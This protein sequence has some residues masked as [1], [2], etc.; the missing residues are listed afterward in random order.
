MVGLSTSPFRSSSK[1]ALPE[2][3]VGHMQHSCGPKAVQPGECNGVQH[4][5]L[6]VSTFC[7]SN[8][9]TL[10]SFFLHSRL[11]PLHGCLSWD[12][13][14][15]PSLTLFAPVL[16][17]PY[18]MPPL[19]GKRAGLYIQIKIIPV[20]T[21]IVNRMLFGRHA[22]TDFTAWFVS[23]LQTSQANKLCRKHNRI[24]LLISGI[25]A[26]GDHHFQQSVC[27]DPLQS[28]LCL[29]ISLFSCVD[30]YWRNSLY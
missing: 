2:V 14:F 16:S 12:G 29:I 4:P 6:I 26:H 7:M 18:M 17:T 15:C 25:L 24:I 27:S 30:T 9:D 5:S 3:P 19:R 22:T 23:A 21:F 10:E 20:Q 13:C 11:P 28:D 1:P 8:V